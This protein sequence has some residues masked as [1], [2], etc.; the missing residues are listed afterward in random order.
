MSKANLHVYQ[1]SFRHESRIL[2]ETR[3]ICKC[4]LFDKVYIAAIWEPGL[5]EK[6]HLDVRREVWRVRLKT[7]YLPSGSFWKAIR[8]IEWLIRIFLRF[9]RQRIALINCHSL[10]IL[11]LGIVFKHFLRSKLVYDTHEL[12]TETTAM[13]K[14]R[15]RFS[16]MIE[17]L[18][19]HK[20]DAVVVVSNSIAE[21]YR[22]E[23][24]LKDVK[25]IRN[26][27]E[28]KSVKSSKSIG[29]RKKFNIHNDEILYICQ[30]ALDE[31]RG[32]EILLHVFSGL[33]GGKHIV[34]MGYGSLEDRIK[35]YG[36]KS[37]NIHFQP[38]VRPDEV[39]A[40]A[41]SADVGIS[42]IENTCL[43]YLYSLPNKVF[44]Y[45]MSGLPIIVSDFPDMGQVVDNY[46][47]G[48]KVS[49][50]EASVRELIGNMSKEEIKMKRESVIRCKNDFDWQKE[51]EELARVYEKLWL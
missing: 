25:V 24:G 37:P 33:N 15:K 4:G 39:L 12:E 44:E 5:K 31:D 47:C 26:V 27:P 43:S 23:Y 19:V 30:G 29:L 7:R 34:F 36:T 28:R 3:S 2:K 50:N 10:L 32:I 16:K 51:E 13:S 20:A 46:K 35:E 14:L 41:S 9:R 40:Y 48:W 11:P 6:E 22:K 49:V 18:L 42:L 21:W 1:S 8:F 38:A 17:R 45:I